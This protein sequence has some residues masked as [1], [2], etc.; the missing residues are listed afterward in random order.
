MTEIE[1]KALALV[2]D[3]LNE[4]GNYTLYAGISRASDP[5]H[6][7]ICRLIEQHE[8]YKQEVS[9]VVGGVITSTYLPAPTMHKLQRFIIVKPDPLAAAMSEAYLRDAIDDVIATHLREA[10]AKR[11]LK[12]VETEQ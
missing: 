4:R 9:D 5:R 10:L 3:V 12:I 1:K 8:A 6:E 11:G 7:V 2:N